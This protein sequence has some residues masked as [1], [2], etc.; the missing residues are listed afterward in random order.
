MSTGSDRPPKAIRR[1]LRDAATKAYDEELRRALAELA[2]AFDEWRGGRLSAGQL[3]DRVHRFHDGPARD[4][5]KKY[6]YAPIE[7]VVA[8]AIVTGLLDRTKV[9]H[10]LLVYLE[11]AIRFYED[12]DRRQEPHS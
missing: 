5:W 8:Y 6:N 2:A 12:D 4:L 1:A 9:S 7:S 3:T 10:D 11:R